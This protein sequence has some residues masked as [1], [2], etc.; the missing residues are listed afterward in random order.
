MF[1][2]SLSKRENAVM[3]AVF[4][5]SEGKERFLAA[6]YELLAML[7]PRLKFDEEK[8]CRALRS[9]EL[10]GYFELI[11]SE[12]KGERVFVIIMHD[13]GR[14]FKRSDAVR[15]RRIYYKIALTLLCGAL[16]ALVGILVKSLLG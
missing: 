14:S 11:E 1:N 6:P 13:A 2:E 7:S 10:D 5:L 12:R 15:R 9:L 4:R 3:G 16:S 8:L